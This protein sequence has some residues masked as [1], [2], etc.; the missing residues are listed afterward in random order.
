M[1]VAVRRVEAPGDDVRALNRLCF[2][3]DPVNWRAATWWA[4]SFGDDLVAFAGIEPH[5]RRTWYLSRAGVHP[6]AR[7]LGLQRRLIR[8]REAHARRHGAVQVISDTARWNCA[9]ANNLIACSYRLYRPRSP[10]GLAGSL[11]FRKSL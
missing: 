5:K 8:V 7:G 10:W 2:R 3:D 9:S 4:A 1:R 6:N 11:Y